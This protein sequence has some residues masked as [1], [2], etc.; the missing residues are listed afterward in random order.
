MVGSLILTSL[1]EDLDDLWLKIERSE[2]GQTAGFG[3][4]FH[5]IGQNISGTG[6]V[7]HRRVAR[8]MTPLGHGAALCLERGTGVS[9]LRL[10]F[11]V[12]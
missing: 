7:S 3:P 1:L 8:S 11:L 5:L 10:R 2:E 6:F 4:C 9:F 12:V